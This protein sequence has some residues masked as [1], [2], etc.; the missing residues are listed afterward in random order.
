MYDCIIIGAGPAGATA[1]YNLAQ[2]GRSVLVIEKGKFPRYKPCGGGVSPAIADWFDF[3]FTPVIKTTVSNVKYTW[4]FGD[5]VEIALEDVAPMWMVQ[6][7]EFD[8]FLIQKAIAKGAEF[9]DSTEVTGIKLQNEQWQVSTSNGDFTSS[10]LIAADGANGPA[11]GWLGFESPQKVVAAGLEVTTEVTEKNRNLAYFD[12]GSLKNGFMWSFPKQ[13]G[14]SLSGAFVR[15][16]KGKPQEIKKQLTNFAGK[17]NLDLTNSQYT[18][19]NL[20]LW[21]ADSPLHT[22][23]ALVVGEAGGL[24]DP[25][26]GEGIRPAIFTGIK[27][28]A[29][30]SEALDGDSSALANYSEV[31]KTE[32][33]S[34]LAKAQTVAG[35][36]FK[37]PKIAYKLG[38]KRPAAGQMMGK[39]LCGELSYSDVAEK[40]TQKL[41]IPGFGR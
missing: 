33:G 24:V 35:M 27:A 22:N 3:D 10:Y 25:L 31:V 1:A 39:I 28:A 9:K 26:I 30:I 17:F 14:Y 20:N 5:P 11:A 23:R 19:S 38:V 7:D 29:A 36:F 2:Q 6:R 40:V 21:Q 4:K 15:D 18:E 16:P 8:N 32:W 41:K 34:N 13:D 12:F 37:F